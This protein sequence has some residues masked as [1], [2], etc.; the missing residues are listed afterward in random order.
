VS[1]TF[2]DLQTICSDYLDDPANGYFTLPILKQRLNLNLKELQKR[3]ISAN[4]DYY[5]ECVFTNTVVDQQAYALPSDF[6]QVIRLEYVMSG[7]GTTASTQK[8]MPITP[9]QRDLL[10]DTSGDPIAYY[11]QKNN[12]MLAPTPNRIIELHLEYSYLVADMVNAGDVPDA[13]AQF[14]EY[15]AL[16]TVRDL[17]IKDGR[18]IAPIETKLKEY[19]TLLKQIATQ[20]RADAPRMVVATD[21]WG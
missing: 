6:V 2:S 8:I 19:E 9:N 18:S 3:L 15:I 7:S 5:T 4:K 1:L 11:M 13:P 14:H 10:V 12:L 16:M 21:E 20:R 17:M